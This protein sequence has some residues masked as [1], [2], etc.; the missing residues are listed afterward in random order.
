MRKG[1][2]LTLEAREKMSD[3][4]KGQ[5]I[6]QEHKDKISKSMIKHYAENPVSDKRKKE[7]SKQSKKVWANRTDAK[8]NEIIRKIWKNAQLKPNKAETKLNNILQEIC[9]N[10]YRYVGNFEFMIGGKCP[11]FMNIN[12]Q[13]KLIELNGTY[14]HHN[15]NPQDR[16]DFFKKYGFST[17]IIWEH[18]L[19]DI[20]ELKTKFINFN[21]SK[22]R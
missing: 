1:S 12:G 20:D 13:K 22:K 21:N 16:I 3:S 5:I 8:K 4:S 11:D 18:E 15:D 2:H 6:T 14:W 17:L 9:P 19:K 7:I 10:E